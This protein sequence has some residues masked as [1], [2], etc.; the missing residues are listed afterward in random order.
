MEQRL[1]DVKR[2]ARSVRHTKLPW[3]SGSAG[4]EAPP[5]PKLPPKRAFDRHEMV[6]ACWRRVPA[7]A[8]P[9]S[10]TVGKSEIL[11]KCLQVKHVNT[12]RKVLL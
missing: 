10:H 6:L 12:D 2:S 8:G 1:T 7:V 5:S 3:Q 9:I 11:L 4:L